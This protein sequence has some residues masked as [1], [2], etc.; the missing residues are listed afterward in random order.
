MLCIQYLES[1]MVVTPVHDPPGAP[2]RSLAHM[3][4]RCFRNEGHVTSRHGT[5]P[6][7]SAVEANHCAD[8][9]PRVHHCPDALRCQQV[10][11]HAQDAAQGGNGCRPHLHIGSRGQ[12]QSS[13]HCPVGRQAVTHCRD[14]IPGH[15]ARQALQA[16]HGQVLPPSGAQQLD[17]GLVT[18]PSHQVSS[19]H[20]EYEASWSVPFTPAVPSSPW[21]P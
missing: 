2:A 8:H 16:L 19:S 14:H 18:P 17:V 6:H 10:T 3:P 21:P 11:L 20:H 9:G 13:A 12:R 15:T 7:R 4:D 5:L 1:S